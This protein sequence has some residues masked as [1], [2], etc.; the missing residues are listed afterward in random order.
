[1][2]QFLCECM[3]SLGCTSRSRIVELYDMCDEIL[4]GMMDLRLSHGGMMSDKRI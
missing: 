2:F 3:F 1:M 4:L